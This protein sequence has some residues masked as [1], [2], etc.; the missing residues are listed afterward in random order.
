M[1][2]AVR[3]N[4]PDGLWS[5][6]PASEMVA[7]AT[8]GDVREL[9]RKLWVA[10][11]RSPGR[12]FHA[13]FDRICRSDVLREAWRRVQKNKGA[14]GVDRQTLAAVEEYGVERLLGELAARA[15]A[16]V[17]IARAGP[18]GRDS[19]AAGWC[20]AVG[21]SD[22]AAI[23]SCQQAA[24]IVL[25]P[26]FEADFLVGLVWVSATS[27]GDGCEGGA[28]SIV[29]RWAPVRVRGRHP[30]L[31]SGRSITSRLLSLVAE[32][33]S[34]RRVLKLVAQVA[35]GRGDGRGRVSAVDGWDSTGRGDLAAALEHLSARAGSGVR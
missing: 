7:G 16:R 18:A 33:V 35:P 20:A 5:V 6:D 22:R 17:V 15:F 25:E 12:R 1:V 11:K 32:R 28:A 13:L 31:L 34:D 2:G 8:G 14:A 26:I 4:S 9:Q 19:Q 24:R 30:G 10:A 29:H 23:G 3:S 27:V 21:H